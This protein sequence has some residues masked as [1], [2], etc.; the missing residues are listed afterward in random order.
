[1]GT[2]GLRG[3]LPLDPELH[4][5]FKTTAEY[6]FAFPA[7]TYPIDK[8]GGVTDFG[9][10][11]NGPDP[12]LTVNGGNPMG[13]C[14][15]NAVPKNV[16]QTTAH[17][18]GVEYAALTSNQIATLYA[19]Y[20]AIQAGSSWRPVGI[21]WVMPEGL[22]AGVDLGSWLLWLFQQKLIEGFLRLELSEMDAALQTFDAVVVG[23]SLNDQADQQCE[24]DQ[25]WDIGMGDEPD[26]QDGHAIQR[27]AV[28]SP[29]GLRKWATWGQVQPSTER[30]DQKCPQQA[31]AVL[32][33]EQA[34]AVAF[35]YA[36]LLADLK[37]LGGTA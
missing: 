7:V 5:R 24:N 28:E 21:D 11:G 12:T 30:W 14:G 19:T 23:V 22:D 31:F 29:T 37:A 26:P 16:N 1:M 17:L 13:D 27:L 8:S 25:P 35:P 6:G 18:L 20:E 10:G 4:A 34:V 33:E 2:P 3:L 36:A 15:P 32:T 9:M